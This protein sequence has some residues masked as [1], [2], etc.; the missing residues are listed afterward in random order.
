[1]KEKYPY[2]WQ[3]LR[4]RYNI[5]R[6]RLDLIMSAQLLSGKDGRPESLLEQL[7]YIGL[8]SGQR[9]FT[10]RQWKLATGILDDML[11]DAMDETPVQQFTQQIL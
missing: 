2:T 7:R 4:A 3:S 6:K 9:Y 10:N 11:L 1:M 8:R 5:K